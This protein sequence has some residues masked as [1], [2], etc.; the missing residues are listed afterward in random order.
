MAIWL[1]TH[2]DS[3]SSS[4][5]DEEVISSSLHVDV[6]GYEFVDEDD[7]GSYS[8]DELDENLM[9]ERIRRPRPATLALMT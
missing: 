8:T 3:E 1:D 4:A 6:L 9:V 2:S 5:H 7:D